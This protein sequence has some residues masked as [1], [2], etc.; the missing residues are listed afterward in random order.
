MDHKE[1]KAL[2]DPLV[3]EAD[4]EAQDQEVIQVHLDFKVPLVTKET[5][6]TTEAHQVYLES[7]V[8][9]DNLA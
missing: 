5:L 6:D 4:P 8:F 3:Q 2:E 1:I 7:K 9:L